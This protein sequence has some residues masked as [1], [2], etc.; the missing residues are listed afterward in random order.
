MI[1]VLADAVLRQVRAG[2]TSAPQAPATED[3][4][5]ERRSTARVPRGPPL[6]RRCPL[7]PPAGPTPPVGTPPEALLSL[8]VELAWRRVR[9]TIPGE[10]D[11]E[12]H[13]DPTQPL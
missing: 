13:E 2:Q 11:D 1:S 12:Q 7:A 9:A 4:P 6:R 8:F 3:R 10:D 5:E